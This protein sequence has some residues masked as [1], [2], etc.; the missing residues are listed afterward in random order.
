MLVLPLGNLLLWWVRLFLANK[1][2]QLSMSNKSFYLLLQVVVV[3]CVMAMVTVEAAVLVSE[4]FVGISLQLSG[5]C[6]GLVDRG[7]Q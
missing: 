1:S 7:S 3:D 5:K 4:P 2:L 6:Q